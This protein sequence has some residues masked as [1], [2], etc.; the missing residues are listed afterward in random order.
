MRALPDVQLGGLS[1]LADAGLWGEAVARGLGSAPGVF[2]KAF[3]ANRAEA[4]DWTLEESPVAIALI[5]LSIRCTFFR[6]TMQELLQT[7]GTLSPSSQGRSSD[8]PKSPRLLSVKLRQLAPQL[9]SIGIDVEFVRDGRQ[10]IVTV[11][12]SERRDECASDYHSVIVDERFR[13]YLD[14]QNR[15]VPPSNRSRKP[16]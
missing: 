13:A 8:W 4:N 3:E 12:M 2:T 1:R 14:E 10:R 7:L 16:A 11:A 6:G 9:R 15:S 5:D